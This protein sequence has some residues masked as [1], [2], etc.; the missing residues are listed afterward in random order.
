MILECCIAVGV[1]IAT[2]HFDRRSGYN[3]FNPGAYVRVDRWQL[4]AYRNSNSTRILADNADAAKY[5]VYGTYSFALLQRT[6]LDVGVA[7]GYNKAVVPVAVIT[8]NF[9]AGPRAGLIPSSP[10]GGSGGVH[11]AHEWRQQ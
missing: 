6:T 8:Y 1:H 4:G 11:V 9:D 5:S 3:E 2:Y 10:K 7:T